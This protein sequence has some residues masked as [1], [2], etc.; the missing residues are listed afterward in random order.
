MVF[1]QGFVCTACRTSCFLLNISDSDNFSTCCCFIAVSLLA[2]RGYKCFPQ[3]LPAYILIQSIS[4]FLYQLLDLAVDGGLMRVRD[5]G[6][7]FRNNN[8]C[9]LFTHVIKS[10]LLNP[11]SV[12]NVHFAAN[13]SV[14]CGTPDSYD[15]CVCRS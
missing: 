11:E 15:Q 7:S 4:Y 10:M 12:N 13:P 2:N 14:N 9:L 5:Y 6:V 8:Q 3:K 1:P